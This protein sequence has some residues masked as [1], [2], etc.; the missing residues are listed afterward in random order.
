MKK[1][2]LSLICFVVLLFVGFSTYYI[3]RNNENITYTV[4][5]RD[6]IY[7]NLG[8]SIT[9][10]IIHD[11]KAPSTK[12][13]VSMSNANVVYNSVENTFFANKTGSTTIACVPS[14]AN[15][16][17]ITFTIEIGD[18]SINHP[19]FIRNE[20]DLHKI[21]QGDWTLAS[22]YRLVSDI[23]LT[24]NFK[25]IG[26]EQSAFIGSL[27][28]GENMHSISNLNI[29]SNSNCAGLF[30]HLG[31]S[32]KIERV[33]F[34]NVT[35]V[36]DYDYAGVI[37]G[38]S[39]G[40]IGQ[41]SANGVQI[42]NS[43]SKGYTGGFVGLNESQ[44]GNGQ[45]SLCTFNGDIEARNFAGGLVGYNKGGII[46]NCKTTMNI[47]LLSSNSVFGGVVG[48]SEYTS[49]DYDG[50]TKY[51]NA[52]YINILTSLNKVGAIGSYYTILGQSNVL[53]NQL[54]TYTYYDMLLTCSSTSYQPLGNIGNDYDLINEG[55]TSVNY[56]SNLTPE[57]LVERSSFTGPAGSTWDFTSNAS[58]DKLPTWLIN[59]DTI[60]Q[61]N[62]E[63]SEYPKLPASANGEIEEIT[64]HTQIRNALDLLRKYPNANFAFRVVS[65]L[66]SNGDVYADFNLDYGGA[67][68]LPI[69]TLE[70]PF[71]GK[72]IVDSDVSLIIRNYKISN[73]DYSGFFGV[74]Q[75]RDTLIE[76]ITFS[77]GSYSGNNIGGIVGL[78]DGAT[79]NNCKINGL[80]INVDGVAGGMVAINKGTISATENINVGA[81]TVM[82]SDKCNFEIKK[83]MQNE[84]VIGNVVGENHGTISDLEINLTSNIFFEES[85]KPVYF[86]G[87][88][89]RQ[90]SGE[91]DTCRLSSISTQNADRLLG[92]VYV[93]GLVGYLDGGTISNSYTSAGDLELS[94]TRDTIGGGIA[95]F[96]GS[97]GLI[98]SCVSAGGTIA[99]KYAG[100]IAGVQYGIINKS[101]VMESMS[102]IGDEVGG[103]VYDCRGQI[104]NSYSLAS[105]QGSSVE[106]GFAT[107]LNN[108][109]S[110][111]YCYNY[112]AYLGSGKGYC[113]S[114]TSFRSSKGNR[115][116]TNN[117]I[118]GEN[119]GNELI[120]FGDMFISNAIQRDGSKQVAIQTNSMGGK[121]SYTIVSQ[122]A[123]FGANSFDEFT[124]IGFD[125]NVWEIVQKSIDDLTFDVVETFKQRC[126]Q[127]SEQLQTYLNEIKNADDLTQELIEALKKA[128]ISNDATIENQPRYLSTLNLPQVPFLYSFTLKISLADQFNG[129][130]VAKEN[131]MKEA[132]ASEEEITVELD[133]L[134]AKHNQ[135]KAMVKDHLEA[136]MDNVIPSNDKL[137]SE[138]T[139][140]LEESSW[141][142]DIDIPSN[143]IFK[144]D[145][146]E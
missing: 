2:C 49:F 132:G 59:R 16:S 144:G 137:F 74:A 78:N 82:N 40:F 130:L 65:H 26:D 109:A 79:I 125:S 92:K 84:V 10:P 73:D 95:G 143:I 22:N 19:F 136:V 50:K 103:I 38:I 118:V 87:I 31:A 85:D 55:T 105:L 45:I 28:G 15:F 67:E 76:N 131:E 96:L 113:E 142:F 3:V 72:F 47:N 68:I 108:G 69:G 114:A 27:F 57:Q 133:A 17:S 134:K 106:A 110:I 46:D 4:S 121:G 135:I 43:S 11:N 115:E 71:I 128:N 64:T 18:G 126:D 1:F 41:C 48:K 63:N 70:K 23:K 91:I 39:K 33:K 120:I 124:K 129:E 80:T 93:G 99:A 14:N 9:S 111:K 56:Y 146:K 102:I 51:S 75:G 32:A 81:Y 116:F 44:G 138:L 7:L 61:I 30:A 94:I 83:I 119:V 90:Y 8:E 86:G 140:N 60:I 36:G 141:I 21:G 97:N 88:A 29:I 145:V 13:D 20:E 34:E 107:Y 117:I 98:E 35:I 123:A 24:E 66:T 62:Y 100:G 5:D 58:E 127:F 53:G 52:R 6:V 122:D 101:A 54:G 89:G 77:N 112:C 37:A 139:P 104:R 42:T 25:T 12:I